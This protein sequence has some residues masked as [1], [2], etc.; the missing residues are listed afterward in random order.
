M[1]R[2]VGGEDDTFLLSAGPLSFHLLSVVP[3]ESYLEFYSAVEQSKVAK[4]SIIAHIL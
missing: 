1:L 3:L 4:N 2:D